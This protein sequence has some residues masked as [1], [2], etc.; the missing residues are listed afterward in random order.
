MYAWRVAWGGTIKPDDAQTV[1]WTAP[2]TATKA[3]TATARKTRAANERDDRPGAD[4]QRR[5]VQ[6]DLRP[7]R[8]HQPQVPYFQSL[9]ALA[10]HQNGR[11]EE[12]ALTRYDE[13]PDHQHN[14]GTHPHGHHGKRRQAD[15]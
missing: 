6:Q 15:L 4:V 5:P 8:L 9:T 14:G 7:R 13:A 12:H 11:G 1:L 3:A 10:E 2:P